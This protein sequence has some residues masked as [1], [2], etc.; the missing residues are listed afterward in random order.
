[1]SHRVDQYVDRF[2]GSVSDPLS[3]DRRVDEPC[4]L[5]P[6]EMHE[7]LKHARFA[8]DPAYAEIKAGLIA[9]LGQLEGCRGTGCSAVRSALP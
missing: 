9:K 7:A 5:S 1:M 8:D 3:L 6:T 4:G 2:V